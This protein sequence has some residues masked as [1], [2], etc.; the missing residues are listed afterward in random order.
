MPRLHKNFMDIA[1]FHP[2][3]FTKSSLVEM[4]ICLKFLEIA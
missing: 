2:D 4:Q 1:T 3:K